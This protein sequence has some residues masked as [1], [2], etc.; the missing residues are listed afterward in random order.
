MG[1]LRARLFFK[2]T[3]VQESPNVS[4]TP[5]H[6]HLFWY[7]L[8]TARSFRLLFQ[9]DLL[10]VQE[11]ARHRIVFRSTFAEHYL[12]ESHAMTLGDKSTRTSI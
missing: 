6:F 8:P 2:Y 12:E 3:Y 9:L 10:C 11:I 4:H 1:L 5:H 7:R